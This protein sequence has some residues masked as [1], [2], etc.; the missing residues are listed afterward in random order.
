VIRDAGVVEWRV[1]ADNKPVYEIWSGGS[2][3]TFATCLRTES[4]RNSL[5]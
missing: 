4:P 1:F 2:S 5:P 3:A